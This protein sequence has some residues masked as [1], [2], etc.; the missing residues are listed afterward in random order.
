MP[1]YAVSCKYIQLT[2]QMRPAKRA[3]DGIE[4]IASV[5]LGPRAIHRCAR[6]LSR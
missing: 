3:R 6:V 5:Q 2:P 4:W 1:H